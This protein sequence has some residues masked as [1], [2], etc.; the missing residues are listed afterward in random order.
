MLVTARKVIIKLGSYECTKCVSSRNIL[1]IFYEV[2]AI[3]TANFL[4][5]M[6]EELIKIDV[7]WSFLG[8][9][10]AVLGRKTV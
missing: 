10:W 3:K 5:K 4:S 7:F 8:L 9:K 1:R 2:K 6:S